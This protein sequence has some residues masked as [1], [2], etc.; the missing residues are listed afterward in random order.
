MGRPGAHRRAR[1]TAGH[2]RSPRPVPHPDLYLTAL[3]VTHDAF[4]QLPDPQDAV[5]AYL[6]SAGLDQTLAVE[7][8]RPLLQ[9]ARADA[10][11]FHLIVDYKFHEPIWDVQALAAFDY[12][13]DVASHLICEPGPLTGPRM[14]PFLDD[15]QH[16]AT[17]ALACMIGELRALT[18]HVVNEEIDNAVE[19]L[20]EAIDRYIDPQVLSPDDRP[21]LVE[22]FAGLGWVG[23]RI[24]EAPDDEETRAALLEEAEL[25]AMAA[26][27]TLNSVYRPD[28]VLAHY[29]ATVSTP[30][31]RA[32][33]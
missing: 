1:P 3:T 12:A 31:V 7:A 33:G 27:C 14:Q 5:S 2:P 13:H 8:T 18:R 17:G 6:R 4:A 20:A 28:L 9:L 23:Q 21:R 29:I 24:L 32:V 19:P 15:L 30:A 26:A 16:L 25:T 10:P 11:V 22:W